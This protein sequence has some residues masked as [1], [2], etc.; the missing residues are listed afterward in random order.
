MKEITVEAAWGLYREYESKG[1]KSMTSRRRRAEQIGLQTSEEDPLKAR[2][3]FL[4]LLLMMSLLGLGGLHD[5][6][7]HGSVGRE[8]KGRE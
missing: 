8:D 5:N 4:L 1:R 3:L 7:E 2:G 6:Q